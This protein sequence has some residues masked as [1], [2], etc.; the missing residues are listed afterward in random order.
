MRIQ[1]RIIGK[2]TLGLLT[3]IGLSANAAE[4]EAVPGEYIVKMKPG[5]GAMS[6]NAQALGAQL[7]SF[8]KST[9]PSGNLVVVKRPAFEMSASAVK[10]LNQNPMVDFAEPNYIYRINR[11]PNDPLLGKL[12]GLKN[13]G[14][15]DK[16]AGV[17]G[18]D[19][20]AERAWDITTGSNDFI[21]AVIDTGVDYTHPDLKENIWTNEAEANGQPGVDDDRPDA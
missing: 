20:D 10:L 4:Y 13:I 8:V 6:M 12:W 18:V 14:Q 19:I 11:T 15:V 16:G 2:L 9:I 17:V 1:G 3:V 7:G 21:I 5:F